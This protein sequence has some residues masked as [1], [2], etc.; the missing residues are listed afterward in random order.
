VSKDKASV[1]DLVTDLIEGITGVRNQLEENLL[2]GVKV[3]TT[4]DGR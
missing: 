1:K 3:V 2:V 4:V